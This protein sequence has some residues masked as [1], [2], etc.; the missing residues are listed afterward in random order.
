M[1]AQRPIVEKHHR[2]TFYRPFTE[3]IA[4]IICDLP[5]K[6]A[7]AI[8]FN[9][10]LYFMTNLRRSAG[11]FFNY[12]IFMIVTI[13]TMSMFFRIVGSLSKTVE[14][15]M[16]PSSMVILI[17]SA[18]T[19]YIIPIKDMVPWLDW[20]RRLNPIAFAYESLM[21]NEVCS[22]ASTSRSFAK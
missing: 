14:Q 13:L 20:L 22:K 16:V 10:P 1:W 4:S 21:I 3:S 19:G 7:T 8:M 12:L 11:A 15:S 17:F 6:L 18:Y 9:A 5:N 2:Y